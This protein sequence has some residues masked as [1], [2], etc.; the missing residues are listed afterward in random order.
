[1]SALGVSVQLQAPNLLL[2]LKERH[3]VTLLFILHDLRAVEFPCDR[4]A[5]MT[6]LFMV[7]LG[8]S[9]PAGS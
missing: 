6:S 7:S 8:A 9:W 4:I 1:M 2:D 5:V 3:G